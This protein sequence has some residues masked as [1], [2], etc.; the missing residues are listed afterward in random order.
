M[1]QQKIKRNKAK[2]AELG[3]LVPL[4]PRTKTNRKKREAMQDDVVRRV[5]PKRY[6]KIP[7]S[8]K[9]L[10]D[11]VISKRMQTIN[12]PDTGEEDTASKR[13]R[14]KDEAEYS[15]SDSNY[16]DVDVDEDE[17]ESCNND[18]DQLKRQGHR[19]SNRAPKQTDYQGDHKYQSVDFYKA[20]K[21]LN[22][23][24][25]EVSGGI[26]AD[27]SPDP[28]PLP[29][30][31]S[32][33]RNNYESW[34]TGHYPSP[35][36]G[37]ESYTDKNAVNSG[38]PPDKQLVFGQMFDYFTDCTLGQVP[39]LANSEK[40]CHDEHFL[41]G[42]LADDAEREHWRNLRINVFS[43]LIIDAINRKSVNA[44]VLI[45]GFMPHII[46]PSIIKEAWLMAID[47]FKEQ[48]IDDV[49]FDLQLII[50][51]HFCS[52]IHGLNQYQLA[53]MDNA[54]MQSQGNLLR[55]ID[56]LQR[57]WSPARKAEGGKMKNLI[58]CLRNMTVEDKVNTRLDMLT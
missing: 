3:L 55:G 6:V 18:D 57:Q 35:L 11:P 23:R 38:L 54:V 42:K 56:Y 1:R 44:R 53:L 39:V 2:L 21:Q 7:T 27:I 9:D 10:D 50:S 19:F 29:R 51:S 32:K 12:S 33:Q 30:E 5:Q 46:F 58:T 8:Y 45:I 17:L 48:G 52:V 41:K 4:A 13:M 36:Q 47:H 20:E 16:D 34:F 15:P 25:V 24:Y 37:G 49:K 43:H 22:D 40:Y 28:L 31:M 26:K 14:I